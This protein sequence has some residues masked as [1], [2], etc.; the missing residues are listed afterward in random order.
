[1]RKTRE[2]LRQKWV[3]KRTH[4]DVAKSLGVSAG[5]VGSA[6]ARAMALQLDWA[7]IETLTD[8]DLEA[9]LYSA[10]ASNEAKPLP[11]FGYIH[12]ERK[13]LGVTLEL[14]HLEYLEQHPDGYRYTQFCEHYRAWL[15]KRQLTMRQ[16][17]HAGD[18]CFVDYSG[19]RPHIIDGKT[20]FCVIP[21]RFRRNFST[22]L[23]L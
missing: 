4:R 3:L 16:E 14:L 15:T 21:A 7:E 1:M 8:A 12:A 10:S 19:G 23:T 5:A 20:D 2:I 17:H 22:S 18:K 9:K 6:L 11:N 13:K